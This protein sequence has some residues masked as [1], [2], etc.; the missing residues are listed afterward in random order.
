MKHLLKALWFQVMIAMVLG[1]VVG[2]IISPLGLGVLSETTSEHVA[3]WI[4]LP[5]NLFLAMIRMV[6]MPLVL[7]SIVLGITSS[8]DVAFL[9]KVSVRIF[10]ILLRPRW[11]PPPL[12]R[13]RH[14]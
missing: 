5:G 2:L 9:K 4:A 6:V 3:P 14:W 12:V 7:S 8:E 1:L 11:W 13:L 10:L